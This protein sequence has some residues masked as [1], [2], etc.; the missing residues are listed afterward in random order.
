VVLS[1]KRE[2]EAMPVELV[3]LACV[4]RAQRDFE[5][6]PSHR[7]GAC[8]IE[9]AERERVHGLVEDFHAAGIGLKQ[10]VNALRFVLAK[11]DRREIRVLRGTLARHS[12]FGF[13]MTRAVLGSISRF[14]VAIL[15]AFISRMVMVSSVALVTTPDN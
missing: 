2:Q 5:G 9:H 15:P 14:Q 8:A 7:I 4:V 1:G 12:P 13:T 3:N 10:H 11:D 6:L